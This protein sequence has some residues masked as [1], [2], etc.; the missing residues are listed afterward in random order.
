MSL[1][2]QISGDK[3]VHSQVILRFLGINSGCLEVIHSLVGLYLCVFVPKHPVICVL[4]Q[5]PVTEG[6][7]RQIT[8]NLRC[9]QQGLRGT[10]MLNILG[11]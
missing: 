5:C 7:R 3:A 10:L 9:N 4:Q 6:G 11:G 2:T 1:R 8:Q